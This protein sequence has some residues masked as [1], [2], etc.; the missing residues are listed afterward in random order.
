MIASTGRNTAATQGGERGGGGGQLRD[1]NGGKMEGGDYISL[2]CVSPYST[3][4]QAVDRTNT[5][6][7]PTEAAAVPVGGLNR[8]T[9]RKAPERTEDSTRTPII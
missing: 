9:C 8:F 3:L 7:V 6:G 2:L 4:L 5:S 1:A